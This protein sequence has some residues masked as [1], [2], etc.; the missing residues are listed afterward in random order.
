[1]TK[2]EPAVRRMLIDMDIKVKLISRV[3]NV[4][5]EDNILKAVSLENG[6]TIYGDAFVDKMCIRDRCKTF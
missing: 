6:E 1:M 5:C 3:V 4:E 2:V